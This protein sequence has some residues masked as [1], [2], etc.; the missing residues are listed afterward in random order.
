MLAKPFSHPSQNSC[1]GGQVP[2][3]CLNEEAAMN[4]VVA[5]VLAREAAKAQTGPHPLVLIGI[6]CGLGLVVAITMAAIGF[7]LGVGFF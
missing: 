2:F 6:F 7:D 1:N 5:G 4:A 3:G